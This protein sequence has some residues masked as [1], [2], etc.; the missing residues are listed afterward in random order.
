MMGNTDH[1]LATLNRHQV[2]YLLIGGLNFLLRHSPVLTYDIDIW[3][4]DTSDNR[5]RCASAL[6]ELQA[7]WGMSEDDWGPVA[8][9]QDNWLEH[10]A[11]FCLTSTH[12]AIDIFRSVKGLDSWSTCHERAAAGTTASGTAFFG[13]SDVDML[14]CQLALPEGHR[15]EARIQYLQNILPKGQ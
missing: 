11:V 10:Q 13:L 15:N 12:G 5:R 7:E 6:A 8:A 14:R 2:D 1:I 3:I 4:D 9:K